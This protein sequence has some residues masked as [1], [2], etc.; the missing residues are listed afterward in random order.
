LIFHV[1]G[2]A[3]PNE[4]PHKLY[5]NFRNNLLLLRKNLPPHL[6]KRTL[7]IRKILDGVAALQYLLKGKPAFFMAVLK[8]HRDFNK[9]WKKEY[10][11]FS[12]PAHPTPQ[13]LEGW[14]PKSIVAAFYIS[15]KRKFSDL[16][17]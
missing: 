8:A 10:S 7:F 14:Y 6:Q 13:R 15:G 9:L 16:K 5:L 4:S 12:S 17:G 3:L 11:N 1:G 2:G